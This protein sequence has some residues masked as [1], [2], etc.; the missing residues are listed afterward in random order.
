[1]T[2][3][4]H[5]GI[6]IA[7]PSD[8]FDAAELLVKVRPLWRSLTEG[9]KEAGVKYDQDLKTSASAKPRTANAGGGRR[10]RPSRQ[11]TPRAPDLL[12]AEGT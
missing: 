11:E 7:L 8:E 9:L 5:A 12:G 10:G 3:T 2:T 1:M 6:S 4:L